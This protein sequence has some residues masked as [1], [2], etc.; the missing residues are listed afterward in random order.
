MYLLSF[1]G[2]AIALTA[3]FAYLLKHNKYFDNWM[4]QRAKAETARIALFEF[5]CGVNDERPTD[6]VIFLMQLKLEYFRRYQ[7]E[8]QQR[9]Y[10]GRGKEHEIAA[11]KL[12]SWGGA[13]TF[14]IVLAGA[15]AGVFNDID[16]VSAIALMGVAIPV[17]LSAHSNLSLISQDER[18]SKRYANT[19]EHLL[20]I[21]GE[22]DEIRNQVSSGNK[23]ALL[24]FMN[25]VNNEISVE[26][27]EWISLQ[28]KSIKPKIEVDEYK[29][30]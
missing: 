6:S 19:Y 4:E 26:H 8:V 30:Q 18:N 24:D 21:S 23:Q 9:Y 1:E 29:G 11:N 15:F 14:V 3:L 2:I 17:I 27:R 28:E 20:D 25:L 13:L 12:V 16:M 5:V 7:L 10:E 22:L